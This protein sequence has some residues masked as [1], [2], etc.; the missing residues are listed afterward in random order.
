MQYNNSNILEKG[1]PP[2]VKI[3]KEQILNV[4]I[5]ITREYGYERINARDIAKILK[6]STQPIFSNYKNMEELKS[7]VVSYAINLYKKS[8]DDEIDKKAYP[9]YKATGMGY[10]KFAK[11]EKEFFKLLFMQKTTTNNY[12]L[13]LHWQSVV[14]MAQ[15]SS[16]CRKNVS[17]LF[18]L[19]MWL[20]VHGIASMQAT[21]Y[22]DIDENL[23]STILS[24]TYNGLRLR[25]NGDNYESD[26]N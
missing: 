1:M 11:Y 21:G 4:A 13:N 25:F 2:K 15:K 12:D 18:H 23:I 7:D 6:C 24:D 9:A 3:T 10:I 20:V 8:I 26:N 19:E 17:E 16:C 14:V 5:N 22:M